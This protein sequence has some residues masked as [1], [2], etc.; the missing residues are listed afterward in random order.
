MFVAAAFVWGASSASAVC[1]LYRRNKRHRFD[2]SGLQILRCSFL[3]VIS[4]DSTDN[5]KVL[6]KKKKKTSRHP[7]KS[8]SRL[9][10]E[11]EKEGE[12]EGERGIEG[13][14]DGGRERLV[15]D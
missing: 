13:W 7:E 5:T 6:V 10:T 2:S 4:R 12:G 9:I 1:S 14:R 15:S 8:P 3:S 11:M